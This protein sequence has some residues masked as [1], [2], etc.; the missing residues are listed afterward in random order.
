MLAA[1]LQDI[2]LRAQCEE[3]LEAR[4]TRVSAMQPVT[5]RL[6]VAA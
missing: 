3:A 5:R 1:S 6:H 2:H 4:A